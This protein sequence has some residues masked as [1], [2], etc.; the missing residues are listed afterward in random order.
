M[1]FIYTPPVTP[2]PTNPG[3][4]DTNVQ[5]N[6]AGNFAGSADFSYISGTNTLSAGNIT[7]SALGMTIQPKIPS[8]LESSLDFT[9]KTP[10]FGQP[11]TSVG[12]VYVTAGNAD[13]GL[14]GGR[15]VI[16]GGNGSGGGRVRVAGGSGTTFNGGLIEL[17]GGSSTSARG[18]DLTFIGG[19][20]TAGIGANVYIQ[21]G[22]GQATPG[23]MRLMSGDS[24]KYGFALTQTAANVRIG[25]FGTNAATEPILQPTT[26]FANA[27]F[28]PNASANTVFNE[29]TFDGY[30]IAQ[31]VAAL[32]AFKLL[33]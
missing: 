18:G 16:T 29:S 23:I 24:S 12:W 32:R 15:V 19:A 7:G 4:V 9:L 10:N 11:G 1:S 8:V 27:A 14:T 5:Y 6:N 13:T 25:F 31:V 20:S 17:V 26:A 22:Q 30:R 2:A 28:V 3:G 33:A 21:C